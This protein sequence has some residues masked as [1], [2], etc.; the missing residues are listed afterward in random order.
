MN[1]Q[2]AMMV[3]AGLVLTVGVLSPIYPQHV[4]AIR[5]KPVEGNGVNA[6]GSASASQFAPGQEVKSGEAS[7]ANSVAPG[8]QAAS[9]GGN[10]ASYAPGQEAKQPTCAS[11]ITNQC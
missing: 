5:V 8:Q 4:S 2:I 11:V 9:L 6:G 10:G 3:I 7:T 1:K